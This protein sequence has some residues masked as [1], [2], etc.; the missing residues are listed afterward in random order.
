MGQ[1][2]FGP[3]VFDP[4]GQTLSRNRKVVALGG[5][6][7]PLLRLLIEADGAVVTK[8]NLMEAG[9]PDT[10]V[11]EGYLAVQIPELRVSLPG[12][13]RA[14]KKG[15]REPSQGRFDDGA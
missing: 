10:T 2:S 15:T 3:F 7:A 12:S 11:E 6:A 9:W 8:A 4:Q 13:G 1:I 14:R 5:R